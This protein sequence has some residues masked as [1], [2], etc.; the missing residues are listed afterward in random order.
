[1]LPV[2][3]GFAGLAVDAALLSHSRAELARAVDGAA[4]AAAKEIDGT[5][6]GVT[7]ADTRARQYLLLNGFSG[8]VYSG[9]VDVSFPSSSP[10]RKLVQVSAAENVPLAFMRVFGFE[11]FPISA[12]SRGEQAPIDLVLS[13]DVSESMCGDLDSTQEGPECDTPS[14]SYG[15]APRTTGSQGWPGGRGCGDGS[16]GNPDPC[17]EPWTTLQEAALSFVNNPIFNPTYDQLGLVMYGNCGRLVQPLTANFNLVRGFITDADPP[18]SELAPL[19]VLEQ[20]CG[21]S[22]G[23]YNNPNSDELNS[24]RTNIGDGVRK[25]MDEV[26]GGVGARPEAVGVIVV[27]TDGRANEPQSRD[28]YPSMSWTQTCPAL[29]TN[30]YESSVD[31]ADWALSQACESGVT[32][33]VIH[34]TISLGDDAIQYGSLMQ[35]IADAGDFAPNVG[36]GNGADTGVTGDCVGGGFPDLTDNW[37]CADA[38][39][40]LFSIFADIA[41]KI[42]V[43]I[44]Q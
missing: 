9:L 6:A 2:L 25:A 31:A 26:T 16:A 24:G 14:Y 13:L 3:M 32:R 19:D 38:A 43:R 27:L 21:T 18:F 35:R 12:S 34:F 30:G 40:D 17:P 1:M 33:G 15:T 11:Q 29:A 37:Y 8:D 22:G 5:P 28:T 42:Y 7:R 4:T 10:P 20:G 39:G 41:S 23:N 44:V 36:P